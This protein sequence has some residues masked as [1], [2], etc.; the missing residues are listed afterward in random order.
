MAVVTSNGP[1]GSRWRGAR[2]RALTV[3]ALL[4]AVPILWLVVFFAVPLLY[5]LMLSVSVGSV[6]TG[7]ST[8]PDSF[9]WDNYHRVLTQNAGNI[10]NSLTI[11]GLATL[12]A[13][14]I[15]TPLAYG[16][17]VHGGRQRTLLMA[18]VLLPFLTSYI[19]R[20]ISWQRVLGAEGPVVGLLQGV[21]LVDETFAIV[22]TPYAV[23]AAL[24]Y[25]SIP[26]IF[27]PIYISFV[28]QPDSL[29]EASEDLYAGRWGRGGFIAGVVTGVVVLAL[30]Y[31]AFAWDRTGVPPLFWIAAAV[32]VLVAGLLS[33]SFISATFIHVLLPQARNGLM[34]AA[35][36][37]LIPAI[38]DY[39]NASLLGNTNTQMIGNVIQQKYLVQ[40]DFTGASALAALLILLLLALVAVYV[41]VV[42]AAKVFDHVG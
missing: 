42:G 2:G 24:T 11:G 21:G 39:V 19:V 32:L 36:L 30:A 1:V 40:G 33:A 5:S 12:L 3:R 17:A 6:A 37:S 29:R 20:I 13:F 25:Q 41:K 27:L 26:F 35:L 38:G 15:G 28:R 10:R 23:V 7:F 4:L 16:V 8:P 9:T 34:G 18:L 14:L 31:L 22:G